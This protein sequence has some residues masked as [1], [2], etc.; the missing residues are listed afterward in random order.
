M[1]FVTLRILAVFA[2]LGAIYFA[3]D[4]WLRRTRRR[5]LEEE[6]EAG[7]APMLTREDYVSKGLADYERS[8]EKK[9]LYGIFALPVV[10]GLIL[11]AIAQ[12]S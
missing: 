8:W 12:L 2:L 11:I 3:V 6:H 5:E 9:A 4:T 7:A 10:V 1:F